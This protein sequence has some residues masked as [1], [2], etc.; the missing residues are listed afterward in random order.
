MEDINYNELRDKALQQFKQGKSLFG[1]EGA[2][3]PLLKRFLE[4]ALKAEMENHLDNEA[5]SDGN[6]RNG[7]KSKTIK[8]SD[9]SFEIETPKDRLSTF[10]PQ[11]VKKRETILAESLQDKIIGLYGL[12]MS[13][14]DITKHIKEIYDTELSHTILSQIT[15]R[16]EHA[17]CPNKKN[18][19]NWSGKQTELNTH[20]ATN[21]DKYKCNT[22]GCASNFKG[23]KTELNQHNTDE[24]PTSFQ[25]A[26]NNVTNAA[27]YLKN[28][29]AGLGSY[30]S[31]SN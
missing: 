4:E 27:N 30:F 17:K 7:K 31:W 24:H 13:Y 14:R 19:C 9:G 1:K 25:K 2:F 16:N 26:K 21:C 5:R 12:G 22:P 18:G 8:S 11:I 15:D 29:L 6:K 10:E 23:N 28:N 20:L 3:A